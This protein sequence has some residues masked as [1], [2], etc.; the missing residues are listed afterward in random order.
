MCI[1]VESFMGVFTSV[2]VP[3]SSVKVLLEASDA[4]EVEP[5]F[6]FGFKTETEL[7]ESCCDVT[8]MLSVRLDR[9]MCDN[10]DGDKEDN[11]ATEEVV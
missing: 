10:N 4:T 11:V 1:D 6:F 5:S 9:A 2:M 3:W 8:R 7:A